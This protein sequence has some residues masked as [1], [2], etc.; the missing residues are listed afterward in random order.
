MKKAW[1][2]TAPALAREREHVGI[3]ETFGMNR[4]AALDVGQRAKP[5]AIDRGKLVILP[6]RRLAPSS[7]DSRDCTPVDL[8][9]R[10]SFASSTSSS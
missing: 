3:A 8:P 1:I 5:V 4:L 6:L 9:A 10:N 2:D 7:F